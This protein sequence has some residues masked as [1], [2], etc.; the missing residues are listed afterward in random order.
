MNE[1]ARIKLHFFTKT[2]KA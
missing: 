2:N 1:K